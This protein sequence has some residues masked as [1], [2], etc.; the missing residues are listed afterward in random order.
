M[1]RSCIHKWHEFLRREVQ[2]ERLKLDV[3]TINQHLL[4]HLPMILRK[5][6]PLVV[7]SA[8]SMERAVNLLSNNIRS[9]SSPGKHVMNVLEK[10]TCK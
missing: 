1:S 8:R 5:F 10:S 2:Q 6:G 9:R 7:Y 4:V 3:F